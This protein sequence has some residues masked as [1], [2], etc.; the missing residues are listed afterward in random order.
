MP[1][2]IE[3]AKSSRAMCRTCRK[4][5]EKGTLRLGEEVV[6]TFSEGG[7]TH[8]WHHLACG[9]KKKP[10]Q[11]KNALATY[12]GEVPERAELDAAIAANEAKQKPV[13]L[14]YA[15]R[16]TTG[17]SHCGACH[18]TIEKGTFRIATEREPDPSGMTM[19]AP[20]F[21]HAK[22]APGEDMGA[23]FESL[24]ENSKG[25]SDADFDELAKA[26]GA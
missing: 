7:T 13:K 20:R 4:T 17:R 14:P 6:N 10:T 16:A 19:G 23:L 15:E 3:V 26:I 25:L 22:C 9:A 18:E 12:E 5:I 24:K 21:W 1:D 2:V 8:L 11:L